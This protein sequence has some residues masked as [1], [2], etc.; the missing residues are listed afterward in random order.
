MLQTTVAEKNFP[1]SLRQLRR[2]RGW[3]LER[4][5]QEAGIA[6]V[7]LNRWETGVHQPRLHEL[8]AVLTALAVT[9]QGRRAVLAAMDAPRAAVQARNE[10]EEIARL[11]GV[12]P[13]P[14]GGDLLRAMRLRQ[15]LSQGEVARR[16]GVTAR[17]LRFWEKGEVR[18]PLEQLQRLCETLNAREAEI[19]ALR[20]TRIGQNYDAPYEARNL[21][22]LEWEWQDL[23]RD[24][25]A[26]SALLPELRLF[27]LERAIWPHAARTAQGRWLLASVYVLHF[28]Y[29][30]YCGY[31]QAART[32]GERTLALIPNGERPEGFYGDAAIFVA[33][34][35]AK[36]G[37]RYSRRHE[38]AQLRRWLPF[39]QLG[40]RKAWALSMIADAF[41]SEGA[42]TEAL[43]VDQEA[44]LL[45]ECDP[46]R[47][48]R[49]RRA[50]VHAKRLLGADR[51]GEALTLLTGITAD[52]LY[53][54]AD[55]ALTQTS[56]H[57]ALG[58]T[59]AAQDW[60]QRA[61]AHIEIIDSAALRQQA[62]A[63][64]R[65]L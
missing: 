21:E 45:V 58:E 33:S 22:D 19:A 11:N 60:L 8:E 26:G 6:R 5:A 61:A 10:W 4:T 39:L 14:D 7:T 36:S 52:T 29:L 64:A 46:R 12:G 63:I 62:N 49:E 51:P 30:H 31:V 65:Q 59:S 54:H 53:L 47:G 48:E 56:A 13:M 23:L 41:A 2:E 50:L 28:R 55:V 37:S 42:W 1:Q 20:D 43:A 24:I 38:A 18:P 40:W 27:A 25:N 9:A 17:T 44:C 32:F 35:H 34:A 57:I 15:G 3:T 16:L